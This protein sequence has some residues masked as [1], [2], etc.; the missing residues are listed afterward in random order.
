M[1]S[2]MRYFQHGEFEQLVWRKSDHERRKEVCEDVDIRQRWNCE[3][4]GHFCSWLQWQQ[5]ICHMVNDLYR[6][7]G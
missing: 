6:R 1:T 4:R 2:L 7:R 3:P 5:R